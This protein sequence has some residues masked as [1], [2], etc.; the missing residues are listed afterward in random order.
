MAVKASRGAVKRKKSGKGSMRD[1]EVRNLWTK[2]A[3]PI[4]FG[5]EQFRFVLHRRARRLPSLNIDPYVGPFRWGRDGDRRIGQMSFLA[6][7]TGRRASEFAHGD[8]V[9]C[10]IRV[11]GAP[12]RLLWRLMVRDPSHAIAAG[13]VTVQLASRLSGFEQSDVSF[14][15]KRDREHPQGWTADEITRAVGR[16]FRVRVGRLVRATHRIRKLVEKRASPMD[17]VKRAWNAERLHTGRRFNIDGSRGI[18]E[19]LE[20]REPRYMLLLGPTIID[21]TI[22]R[23]FRNVASAVVVS[24]TVRRRGR[25]SRKLEVKVVSNDRVRRYGYIV[26]HVKPRSDEDLD[27]PDELRRYAQRVLARVM[28]PKQDLTFSHA[29]IPW[30]DR[31]DALRI[32]IAEA[33]L[34]AIC[35]V[36]DVQ[37]D[38]SPGSYTMQVTVGWADPW[39]ADRRKA[40][41]RRKKE[42]AA[43]RRRRARSDDVKTAPPR[44]R[45]ARMR[46]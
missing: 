44:A 23:S 9:Q 39:E 32:T 31:G 35:F 30:L 40:E 2:P 8:V 6:P 33:D 36:K 34:D 25:R 20:L 37:H 10:D 18:L 24:T 15:F 12:W 29:G 14:K 16:R 27:T 1:G 19:V 26:K 5:R 3:N 21:A 45:K 41:V 7:M 22:D 42:Q 17:V 46:S 13:T 4:T 43:A 28:R 11:D 38:V